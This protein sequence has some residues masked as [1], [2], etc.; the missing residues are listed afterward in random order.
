MSNTDNAKKATVKGNKQ[1]EV[2]IGQAAAKLAAGVKA[3]KDASEVVTKLEERVNT[4]TLEA[5]NL[6]TKISDLKQDFDNKANQ[7]KIELQQQYET[8]RLGFITSYTTEKGLTLVP[9]T[10]YHKLQNDLNAAR[11]DVESQIVA[12]VGKAVGIEKS[13]GANAL[14]VAQLE[15]EKKEASN[16]AEINQL[17]GQVEFLKEQAN[18]WKTALDSEREAGVKRAQAS[19]VGTISVSGA[20]K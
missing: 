18:M 8:N 19:A 2:V 6:E 15:H 7:Q 14:R 20:G 16:I 11:T 1:T 17:K 4:A 10:E 12:A 13:N 9:S 5:T 3:F